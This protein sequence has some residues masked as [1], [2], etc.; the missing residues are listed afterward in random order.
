VIKQLI[1]HQLKEATRSPLWHRSLA[2]NLVLGMVVAYLLLNLAVVG[3]LVDVLL[4]HAFPNEGPVAVFSGGLLYYFA[5][6]LLLRF[7][8][9]K[10][11]TLSI[12]P[13]LHLPI[14]R[15]RLVHYLLARTC[16]SSFNW[17]PW[18][19]FV[20]FAFRAVRVDHSSAYV[21]GWLGALL[22]L[23]LA[24]SFLA[25]YLKRQLAGDLR[26]VGSAA[27][28]LAALVLCDYLDLF[29]MAQLSARLFAGLPEI[30]FVGGAGVLLAAL[31][32]CLNYA[33][34]RAYLCP[35]AARAPERPSPVAGRGVDAL[36]RFGEVGAL[37][38]LEAKL[39]WRNKRP[40]S[41]L[42]LNVPIVLY[43]LMIYPPRFHMDGFGFL[44]FAGFLLTGASMSSYGQLLIGWESRYF[45]GTLSRNVGPRAF[46]L[47]K[48]L[49]LVTACSAGYVLTLPYALFGWKVLCIN[50]AAFLFNVGVNSFL[51]LH[52]ATYN[53]RRIDL[54]K[55]AM[56]NWEGVGAAQFL[57][58]APTMV[59]PVLIYM[60]FGL[61][62]IPYVGVAAIGTVGVLGLS[63]HRIWLGLLVRRFE[64]EKYRIAAGFRMG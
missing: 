34:L 42:L 38:A 49:L 36:S 47:A 4:R 43:G 32:Y 17:L 41:V 13:Y 64:R 40:R 23:V 26:V 5:M 7:L 16:L 25:V 33:L 35:E 1:A 53:R 20:P 9:Q 2:T 27:G 56:M 29:S 31:A 8:L 24:N 58:M 37:I 44:V 14:N 28:A 51:L 3:F 48:F 46:F 50:T 11:P 45:D 19:V 59:L 39:V 60:P 61:V 55:G 12:Q 57:L 62:G 6:D 63:C 21:C 52:F 18:F 15:S 54:S 22:P 10:V 30:L